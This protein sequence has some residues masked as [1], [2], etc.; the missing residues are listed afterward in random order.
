MG[1]LNIFFYKNNKQNV[2]ITLGTG[3]ISV[4]N[5]KQPS[6]IYVFLWNKII[7]VLA[8]FTLYFMR[9]V[10]KKCIVRTFIKNKYHSLHR[11]G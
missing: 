2:P 6:L 5:F 9:D 7:I 8:K 11:E 10:H 1:T 4:E 3:W